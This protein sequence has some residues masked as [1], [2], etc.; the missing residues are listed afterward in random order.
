[1]TACATPSNP[2]PPS[3]P[4]PAAVDPR[5][6]ADVSKEPALPKG[7]TVVQPSTPEEGEATEAF[8]TWVQAS[9]DWGRTGWARASL[10]KASACH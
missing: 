2:A 6:C 9:L 5:V 4:K 7:A 1:M 3:A 10:A 8:L